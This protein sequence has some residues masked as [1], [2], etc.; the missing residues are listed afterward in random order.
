MPA[1]ILN[2]APQIISA[3]PK[4]EPVPS[5]PKTLIPTEDKKK[6][7]TKTEYLA[8]QEAKL[9]QQLTT[10]KQ[11]ETILKNTDEINAAHQ[12]ALDL[13]KQIQDT[14]AQKEQLEQ[15][16]LKLKNQLSAQKPVV[17]PTTLPSPAP[18]YDAG[19]VRNIP[20]NMTKN[21]GLSQVSDTPNV[22]VGIVK[23]PRGNMLPNILV[24]V[25][26]KDGNPVRAFKTNPL[27]QFISATPLTN[28]TYTI[29]LEDPKKQH[30]FDAI[31][32]S[33][34]GQIMSPIEIIGR[35]AREELRKALFNS[36]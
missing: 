27:G 17:S 15:E 23:D 21:A 3:S 29:E 16:L 13:Q 24:E 22:I 20:Q 10:A 4:P 5:E 35:D 12:K 18:R 36:I 7:P 33:A 34:S 9:Q 11:Q 19:H 25:K 28:D 14:H 30:A 26:D 1:P 6:T 8:S 31:Q 2:P 32:I